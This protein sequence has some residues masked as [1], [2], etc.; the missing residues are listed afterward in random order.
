ML[1]SAFLSVALVLLLATSAMAGSANEFVFIGKNNDPKCLTKFGMTKYPHGTR[2]INGIWLTGI[3]LPDD[4]ADSNEPFGPNNAQMLDDYDGRYALLLVKSQT[5]TN[6]SWAGATFAGFGIFNVVSVPVHTALGF[7]HP[8][9]SYCSDKSP[10]FEVSWVNGTTN[11]FS[12]VSDCTKGTVTPAPQDSGW[13]R[14][15]WDVTVAG[16]GANPVIPAGALITAITI[17]HDEEGLAILDNF[18]VNG[19][20]QTSESKSCLPAASGLCPD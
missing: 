18:L 12:V 16:H 4:G 1:R 14:V 9:G 17:V 2:I 19:R 3:G 15:R 7:D 11:G 10:R 8:N 20:L 5:S 6:C 13:S